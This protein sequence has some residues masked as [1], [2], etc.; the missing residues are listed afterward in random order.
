MKQEIA[1]ILSESLNGLIY[2]HGANI[3]HRDVKAGNILLDGSGAVKIGALFSFLSF[4]YPP[5]HLNILD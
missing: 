1:Y 3:I 4:S 5:Y 2:L